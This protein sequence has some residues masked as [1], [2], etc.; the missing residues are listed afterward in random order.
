M[1]PSLYLGLEVAAVHRGGLVCLDGVVLR[2]DL[3]R[4][5]NSVFPIGSLIV[6]VPDPKP[7]IWRVNQHGVGT[8]VGDNL[9]MHAHTYTH[10]YTHRE[11]KAHLAFVGASQQQQQQHLNR[12]ALH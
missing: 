6:S 11:E 2:A 12:Y 1:P 3:R 9:H 7:S 10:G 4:S 5:P 8:G